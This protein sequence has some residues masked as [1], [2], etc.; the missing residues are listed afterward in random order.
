MSIIDTGVDA[1]KKYIFGIALA[2]GVKSAGKF[3]VSWCMAHG[4]KVACV[5][6]GIPVD[7]TSEVAMIGAINSALKVL[8][9][10]LK[11]KYPSTFGWL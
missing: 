7:T 2:K 8:F 11:R 1:A 4:V 9:D 5:A 10:T 6:Y 3:I